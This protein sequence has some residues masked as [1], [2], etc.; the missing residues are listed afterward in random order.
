MR[1][2]GAEN[3][4]TRVS[5]SAE[6]PSLLQSSTT[7]PV[8]VHVAKVTHARSRFQLG[9]IAQVRV[10]S[11]APACTCTKI[12]F[13]SNGALAS[14]CVYKYLT[15]APFAQ[16]IR[17]VNV[18]YTSRSHSTHTHTQ[19]RH[20]HTLTLAI[21]CMC[22]RD[23]TLRGSVCA[24]VCTHMCACFL[25]R[26]LAFWKSA[27]RLGATPVAWWCVPNQSVTR[28]V[29]CW[30]V[31]RTPSA[32]ASQSARTTSSRF[33]CSVSYQPNTCVFYAKPRVCCFTLSATQSSPSVVDTVYL[34]ECSQSLCQEVLS[35][36]QCFEYL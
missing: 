18:I 11:L 25:Y 28:V 16:Y 13:I 3:T 32:R 9:E 29:S 2:C 33:R 6:N 27:L 14:M 35:V 34:R 22:A 20:T 15:T 36:R 24:C 12:L 23:Y 5:Q 30:D 7:Q 19:T 17:R 26:T 4:D 1:E 8:V 21:V 31:Y 10:A